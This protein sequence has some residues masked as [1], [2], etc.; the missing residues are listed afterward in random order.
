MFSTVIPRNNFQDVCM[1]LSQTVKYTAH[2]GSLKSFFGHNT[3]FKLYK[4]STFGGNMLY[5]SSGWKYRKNN[6]GELVITILLINDGEKF[7]TMYFFLPDL[8]L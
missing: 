4:I 1:Y 2:H 3:M 6:V 7:L 8:K 5:P